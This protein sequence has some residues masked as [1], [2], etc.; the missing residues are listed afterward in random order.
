LFRGPLLYARGACSGL[1]KRRALTHTP[2]LRSKPLIARALLAFVA[3][4][5]LIAFV[6][7]MAIIGRFQLGP[8]SHRL[9]LPLVAAGTAILVRCVREFYVA[10]KGTLA[11]WDP[12]RHLVTTGL[13][14]FSRNPMYLGVGLVLLGWAAG[15]GSWGLFAYA[16]VVLVAFH[17]RVRLHE[18]PFLARAHAAEWRRYSTQV[19]RWIFRSRK[20]VALTVLAIV[21]AVPLAG[22]IYEAAADAQATRMFPPPGR[23]VDIGGR[24]LHLLCVGDGEPTVIFEPSGFGSSLS[25]ERARE[26]VASR[27]TACSYDR[28]GMG[29]SEPGLR[30]MSAGALARDLAVL[31]DRA[32][33]RGPFVIV[34]SSIGGLTAEMFARQYPERVSGLVLLDAAVSRLLPPLQ[35]RF[36]RVSAAACTARVL[37]WLGVIRLLDPFDLA[38]A[39]DGARGAAITYG[40]KPFDALCALA[41]GLPGSAA[42]FAAAPP[43]PSGLRMIVMSAASS[44]QLL[45]PRFEAAREELRPLLLEAHKAFAAEAPER[46]WQMVP[47]STHL[48]ANSQPDA[49]ADAVLALLEQVR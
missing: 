40:G 10:G 18:E 39:E 30:V 31:Q 45:P 4:P 37:A 14:R 42:E 12:P 49:V 26:R 27:T 29:W 21:A 7:P 44:E 33:L 5:G 28:A 46:T 11:P 25:G 3:L 1:E 9:G 8:A 48:I 24:R 35:A 23:L 19:P 2:G 16:L 34:A 32:R 15:F 6:I 43:L 47:E 41:R 20:A 38:R 13:Y 36:G 22:L 17:L